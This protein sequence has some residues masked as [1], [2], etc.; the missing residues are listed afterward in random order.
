MNEKSLPLLD[1]ISN[2]DDLTPT[3]LE[4][5]PEF[6]ENNPHNLYR[7]ITTNSDGSICIVLNPLTPI[8]KQ[9][10]QNT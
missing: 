9:L 6:E 10:K 1:L 2:I 4:N 5:M 7:L 3:V 8:S